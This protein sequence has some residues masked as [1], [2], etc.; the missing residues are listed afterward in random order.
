MGGL[1]INDGEDT[2]VK[3]YEVKERLALTEP[4]EDGKQHLVPE[5]SPEARWLFAIPEKPIPF[6]DAVKYGLVEARADDEAIEDEPPAEPEQQ[7][8][9]PDQQPEQKK[10][11]PRRK[12][13]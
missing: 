1:E 12:R 8:P 9:D 11:L 4:D 5:D 13:R 6:E 7:Q 10:G 2:D 3:M